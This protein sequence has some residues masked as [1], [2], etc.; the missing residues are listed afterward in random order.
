M[1]GSTVDCTLWCTVS[2][3]KLASGDSIIMYKIN[4]RDN[5]CKSLDTT[6]KVVLVVGDTVAT[7]NW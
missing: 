7:S 1:N 6:C 3:W 4:D 5:Y 2:I